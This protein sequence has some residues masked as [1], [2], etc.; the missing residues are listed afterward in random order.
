[1]LYS[2]IKTRP[3][4]TPR[5]LRDTSQSVGYSLLRDNIEVLRECCNWLG[6]EKKDNHKKKKKNTPNIKL[7]K[8]KQRLAERL[9]A[10]WQSR[11]QGPSSQAYHG[12]NL[13][14][15]QMSKVQQ[16][17]TRI[18]MVSEG[19][20]RRLSSLKHVLLWQEGHVQPS[21]LTW[22]LATS[23]NSRARGS[24]SLFQPPCAPGRY[25]LYIHTHGQITHSP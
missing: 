20:E 13:S 22:R 2:T 6:E 7:S 24:S 21:A 14:L 5:S 10:D 3:G 25:M 16:I 12:R 15:L 1:M 23:C 11:P 9:Q 8:P 18:R 19:L 4:R 17:T